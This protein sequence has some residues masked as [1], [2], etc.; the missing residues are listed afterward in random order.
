MS[1]QETFGIHLQI[2]NLETR[3][4]K[5]EEKVKELEDRLQEVID[6][7]HGCECTRCTG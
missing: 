1:I 2:S 6:H 7:P 3:I 5:L 4:K